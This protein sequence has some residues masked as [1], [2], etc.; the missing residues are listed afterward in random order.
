MR[1]G[2]RR[3]VA[4]LLCSGAN[5]AIWPAAALGDGLSGEASLPSFG[6]SGA[7]SSLEGSLVIAGSPTEGEQL[8]AQQ[9]AKQ[10]NPE[11]VAARE[12][13]RTKFEGLDPQQSGKLA[14]E[15]FPALIGW[16]PSIAGGSEHSWLH[17]C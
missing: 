9:E 14:G 12:A 2:A 16:P 10:L 8:Q 6:G 3:L 1:F 13:S 11:E 15:T 4:C 5:L 17:H 7:S